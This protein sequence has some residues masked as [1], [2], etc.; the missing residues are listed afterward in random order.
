MADTGGV[1]AIRIAHRLVEAV[2]KAFYTDNEVIIFDSLLREKYIPL[3][4]FSPRLKMPR[5]EVESKL[6]KLVDAHLIKF[7]D[8]T[9]DD[10][11]LACYYID[12]QSFTNVVRY[13]IYLM[14]QELRDQE[15]VEATSLTYECPSCLAEF[16]EMD[17]MSLVTK[18]GKKA[19]PHCS[20]GSS[21][22][23][24]IFESFSPFFS[25]MIFIQV[26]EILVRLSVSRIID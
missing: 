12:F 8:L 3:E 26:K 11:N 2:A 24:T 23:F 9:I 4:E 25:P 22:F 21:F 20:I 10:K 1:N 15:K 17:A 13:R 14:Q 6:R 18:D 7:E 5:M 19:C 16:S